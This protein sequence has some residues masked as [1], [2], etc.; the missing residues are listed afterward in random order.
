M[1]CLNSGSG[2]TQL[3]QSLLDSST[4]A[5]SSAEGAAVSSRRQLPVDPFEG[6]TRRVEVL[7][8]TVH[9]I[10]LVCIDTPGLIASASE[11]L[12]NAKVLRQIQK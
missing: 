11:T 10:P 7:R 12:S 2:K 6:G 8:G 3:I 9:G 4:G 5:D 1:P